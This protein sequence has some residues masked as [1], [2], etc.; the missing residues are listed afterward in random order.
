MDLADLGS[1]DALV[2]GIL[3]QVP[4]MP[5]PVPIEDIAHAVDISDVAPIGAS[6][7]E[8]GLV[9][10]RDK[11]Q[12]VILVNRSSDRRRQRFTV[13]H[14][15][16][17]FLMPLHLP[18]EGTQFM[19]TA[20]DMRKSET[21]K[22]MDRATRMEAEANRFSACM[23]MPANLFRRDLARSAAPDLELLLRMARK[24][25]TSK[26]ATAR[27][28][29]ELIDTPSAAV[30][31]KDGKF[32]YAVW[33]RDFPFIPIRR[34]DPVPSGSLTSRF[35][36]SEGDVSDME[37]VGGHWW[38]DAEPYCNR[39]LLEQTLVQ[40]NGFRLSLL[41]IDEDDVEQK[42]EEE[43]VEESYKPSFHRH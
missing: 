4:D 24:Y 39:Q 43:E 30:F 17:H 25:D 18:D 22:T 20:A 26:E 5:V 41:Q 15:L 38:V 14:E 10:D 35:S 3:K 33:D 13:G 16:G 11:S 2:Q 32:L 36:G 28:F 31:S 34:G 7:F 37:A 19:C 9:T 29:C 12:G 40:I 27:R 42:H 23:L 6:G 21:S 8:G 1:P